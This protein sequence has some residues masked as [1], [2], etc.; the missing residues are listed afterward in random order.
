MTQGDETFSNQLLGSLNLKSYRIEKQNRI[1]SV[2]LFENC[3]ERLAR[4]L[5]V[6]NDD[7]KMELL[8]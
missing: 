2:V 4:F 8:G 7:S 1:P 3:T 5:Y 6:P